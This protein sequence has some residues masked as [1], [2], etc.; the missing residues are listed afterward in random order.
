MCNYKIDKTVEREAVEKRILAR[1]H[2]LEDLENTL[3]HYEQMNV[4]M[5]NRD[6]SITIVE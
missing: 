5:S 2:S 6:G 4:L 3:Y 1:G